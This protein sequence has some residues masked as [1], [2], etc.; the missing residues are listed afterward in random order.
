MCSERKT[1]S[2]DRQKK[3]EAKQHGGVS[4]PLDFVLI[5]VQSSLSGAHSRRSISTLSLKSWVSFQ[6]Q[7][8][9]TGMNSTWARHTENTML[10][11]S[12]LSRSENLSS[13]TQNPP[14]YRS[15]VMIAYVHDLISP[16]WDEM[17]RQESSWKLLSLFC[18][19]ALLPP[20]P[21]V[22]PSQILG[23]SHIGKHYALTLRN[24][25]SLTHCFFHNKNSLQE[26][27]LETAIICAKL[28]ILYLHFI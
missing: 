9:E 6:G 3:N 15:G 13:N 11:V 1:G 10:E 26:D 18:P 19:L 21:A 16:M 12:L 24:A 20:V 5:Y 23:L 4:S 7:H 28:L 14:G 17:Q 8:M 27:E 22:S 25:Y 2:C